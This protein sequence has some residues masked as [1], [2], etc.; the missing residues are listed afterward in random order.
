MIAMLSP[1][2]PTRGASSPWG[3]VQTVEALGP[4]VVSVTTASHGGLRLSPSALTRLPEALRETGHSAKG[5]FEEDCD[6]ALPYLALGL[7]AFE[8]D[9][10]RGAEMHQAAVLT[11]QRW[12]PQHAALLGVAATGGPANG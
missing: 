3:P 4:D 9:A 2:P 1:F 7:D 11:V 5:W 10:V 12:H 6:W 8:A